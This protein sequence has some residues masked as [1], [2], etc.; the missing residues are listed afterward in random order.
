MTVCRNKTTSRDV[1]FFVIPN[2]VCKVFVSGYTNCIQNIYMKKALSL[3]LVTVGGAAVA[4][5][6]VL[7]PTVQDTKLNNVSTLVTQFSGIAG[8]LIPLAVTVGVVAFFWF[9]IK[10]IMQGGDNPDGKGASMKGM[11][12]SIL[13]IFVMVSIWGIV[14]TIGSMFGVGQGGTAP[15]PSVTNCPHGV[16]NYTT[17]A[18][19]P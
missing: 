10:Y 6:T 1:V 8:Q 9:L 4:S 15:I 14:G 7:Q 2:K 16:A 3:L 19:N 13:A 5:A 12:Y 11:G 17:G 18:C